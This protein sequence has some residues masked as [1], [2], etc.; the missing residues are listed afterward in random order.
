[1][2]ARF[3]HPLGD[4]PFSFPGSYYVLG[5]LPEEQRKSIIVFLDNENIVLH[6]VGVT[7]AE[8]TSPLVVFYT[9]H[10]Q[11]EQALRQFMKTRKGNTLYHV[12][13]N[14]VSLHTLCRLG[15]GGGISND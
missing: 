4:T 10:Q 13:G 7:A 11:P 5:Q 6:E 8:S 12:D 9:G 15:R 2:C 14:S 3:L 1:M